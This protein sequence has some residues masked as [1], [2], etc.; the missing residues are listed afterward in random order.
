MK[1]TED[2]K[3]NQEEQ[4]KLRDISQNKTIKM[5]QTEEKWK[6]RER[7]SGRL[8]WKEENFKNVCVTGI[9]DKDE[10][11]NKINIW[12]LFYFFR[13]LPPPPPPIWLMWSTYIA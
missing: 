10:L 4:M 6:I 5:Q 8:V 7:L 12:P 9:L 1:R 11:Q 3:E 13:T 2:G